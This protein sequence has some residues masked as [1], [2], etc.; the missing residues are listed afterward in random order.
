MKGLGALLMTI[1]VVAAGC[2]F[3][4][5][6]LLGVVLLPDAS[7]VGVLWAWD[8][9]LLAFL[10]FRVWGIATD[11]RVD[12]ALSMQNFLHLPLAP[13]DVFVLNAVALHLQP[14]PLIFGAALLGLSLASVFALGPGHVILLPLALATLWCVIALT[15]QLQSYLAALMVNKRRRG[16]IVAVSFLVAMLLIQGPNIY[17][18][19]ELWSERDQPDR[20][21]EHV[22]G[23]PL[24]PGATPQWLLIPNLA[25][26]P[27]WLAYGAYQAKQDRYWP[28]ALAT[29][30]LLGITGWS[31]RRSY[32]ST[33]QVYRRM[34]RGRA[35][36]GAAPA[37]NPLVR[38]LRRRVSDAYWDVFP[39]VS[40]AIGR[41]SLRQWFRSPHGKYALLAPLL[42]L[43]FVL[44]AAL[45][46]EGMAKAQPYLGVGLAA[47]CSAPVAFASNVF[48][49]DR[50]GF[51]VLLAA[52]PPRHLVLLGKHL[53]LIPMTLGPG[54]AAFV[55]VQLLMPQPVL[56]VLASMLQYAAFCLVLFMVGA[57][58]SITNPWAAPFNSLKQ[59]GEAIASSLGAF[60]AAAFAVGL[61][62]LAIAGL[63]ALERLIAGVAWPIPV[64]LGVSLVEIVCVAMWYRHVVL[65]QA[66]AL[67]REEGRILEAI[68]TPVD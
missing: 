33:L 53:G 32:R 18:Q 45:R 49:W 56:H 66:E 8:G 46:L 65:R 2:T 61:I 50:G 67:P 14:S 17:M 52:D 12:D 4:A 6:L 34:E 68:N 48:G 26:P 19:I 58:F 5:A 3:V 20:V 55:A 47:L 15:R 59:R 11:L 54:I 38:R 35:A 37:S 23:K 31:L 21:S 16:T 24:D 43:L 10:F 44:L 60:F 27:G 1:G 51:R 42:V 13:S 9:V 25:L 41:A 28:A 22:N 30:G 7:P 62:M 29:L 57:H 40:A 39:T 64:Y 63:L 36:G